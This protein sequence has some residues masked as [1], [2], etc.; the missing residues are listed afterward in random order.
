[1]KLELKS[2]KN[3]YQIPNYIIWYL[4]NTYKLTNRFHKLPLFSINFIVDM[5]GG[6]LDRPCLLSQ[7]VRF[8]PGTNIRVHEH[9]FGRITSELEFKYQFQA[10]GLKQMELSYKCSP[11]F[12]SFRQEVSSF[13]FFVTNNNLKYHLRLLPLFF[14]CHNAYFKTKGFMPPRLLL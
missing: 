9:F 8:L 4:T 14:K 3:Y 10:L 1:M 2:S 5:L 11:S 6:S 7:R 12:Y 13:Y